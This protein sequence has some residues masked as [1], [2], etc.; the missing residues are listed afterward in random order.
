MIQPILG[1]S[2]PPPAAVERI[3]IS[4][5]FFATARKTTTRFTTLQVKN[6]PFGATV[7]ATW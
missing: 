5:A 4:V 2:A 1:P 6:V 7:Q 3:L